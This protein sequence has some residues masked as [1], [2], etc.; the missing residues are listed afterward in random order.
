MCV[1]A[2][3]PHLCRL[4]IILGAI[5]IDALRVDMKSLQDEMFSLQDI[6]HHSLTNAVILLEADYIT[7]S[8]C[9]RLDSMAGWLAG[10]RIVGNYQLI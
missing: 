8:K 1:Y 2:Y 6:T 3:R 7:L 4:V 10:Y 5:N 9:L